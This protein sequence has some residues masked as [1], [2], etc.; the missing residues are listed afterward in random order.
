MLYAGWAERHHDRA[1]SFDGTTLRASTTTLDLARRVPRPGSRAQHVLRRGRRIGSTTR[2]DGIVAAVLPL[3]PAAERHRRHLAVLG[4]AVGPCRLEP[5]RA[6]RSSSGH[7]LYFVDGPTGVAAEHWVEP[8]G[9]PRRRPQIAH[10][11]SGR[12]SAV[13]PTG[14]PVSSWSDR[15]RTLVSVSA[16]T[17]RLAAPAAADARTQ[18]RPPGL[19]HRRFLRSRRSPRGPRR[20]STTSASAPAG[21]GLLLM[22]LSLG[23]MLVAA[24]SPGPR[25]AAR[26]QRG[27]DHRRV[28]CSALGFAGLAVGLFQ[29]VGAGE[30]GDDG[31]C[32]GSGVRIWDVSMNVEGAVGRA[33]V[34]ASR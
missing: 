16:P 9:A 12:R 26:Q 6:E 10:R 22:C 18:R 8:Q 2:F 5:G 19:C 34:C 13:P 4:A 15:L 20:S 29:R 17:R 1:Q 27:R 28:P 3:L 23:S 11:S 30:C 31:L 21:L 33:G 25:P 32:S 24:L 7:T 14:P